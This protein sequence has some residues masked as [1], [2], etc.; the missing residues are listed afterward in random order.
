MKCGSSWVQIQQ[1][2]GHYNG[3]KYTT[4]AQISTRTV[5][6]LKCSL[7]CLQLKTTTY[8]NVYVYLTT[9]VSRLLCNITFEHPIR[10]T[11]H[12]EQE[13]RSIR[14]LPSF[15]RCGILIF[16]IFRTLGTHRH[17]CLMFAH[18]FKFQAK[19]VLCS[20]GCHQKYVHFRSINM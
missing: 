19:N 2:T 10:G 20:Q 9:Y 3:V 17:F 15:V 7:D 4:L 8:H 5:H 16:N 12:V 13:A 14:K 1:T 11:L 18:R 6:S